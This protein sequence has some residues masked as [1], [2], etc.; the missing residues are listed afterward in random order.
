LSTNGHYDPTKTSTNGSIAS[1]FGIVDIGNHT[2]SGNLYLGPTASY[3][4]SLG[5]ILGTIFDDYNVE[6]PDVVLPMS[7]PLAAPITS[8]TV[9]NNNGRVSISGYAHDFTVAG[10]YE[11]NDSY[12]IYVEPGVKVRLKVNVSNFSPANIHVLGGI[13]NSGS[14][15]VY[16]VSGSGSLTGNITV[17]SN[18]PENFY[19][20]GLPGVTAVTFGGTTSFIGVIYAPEAALTLNGGGNNIGVVG[21]SITKTIRMNGHYNFHYDESLGTNGPSR[22]FVPNSWAEL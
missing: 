7:T 8:L 15:E 1:E 17:D 5:Q 18:R 6:F 9:T 2:I 10:D 3:A 11:V 20:F 21:A 19:Y 14:L 4:S 12:D 13:T 16:Q 22:G